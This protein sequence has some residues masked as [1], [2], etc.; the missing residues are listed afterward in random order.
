[1]QENRNLKVSLRFEVIQLHAYAEKGMKA[2]V[3]LTEGQ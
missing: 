1:M 2:I 3:R